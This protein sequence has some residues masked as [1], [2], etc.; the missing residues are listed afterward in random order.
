[1]SVAQRSASRRSRGLECSFGMTSRAELFVRTTG[2][3]LT[4]KRAGVGRA[5]LS[6]ESVERGALG[7]AGCFGT[8]MAAKVGLAGR[9]EGVGANLIIAIDAL[10][11]FTPSRGLASMDEVAEVGVSS[12]LGCRASIEGLARIEACLEC[13]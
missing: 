6:V 9:E 2:R 13:R 4:Y 5:L 10:V 7:W 1:M 3:G 11:A 12:D 8:V